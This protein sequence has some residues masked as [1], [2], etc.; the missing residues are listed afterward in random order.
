MHYLSIISIYHIYL[1]YLSIIS[2]YLS[3]VLSIYLSYLSI[4][5]IYLS[6][7]LSIY[8]SFYHSIYLP[9]ILSIYHS[10]YLSSSL[11]VRFPEDDE[12]D[13]VLGGTY[14]ACIASLQ[15]R[16]LIQPNVVLCEQREAMQSQRPTCFLHIAAA[17]AWM[18]SRGRR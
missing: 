18:G 14:I 1:S 4:I 2:I 9:I 10:I 15:L 11:Q 7:Y 5:S 13:D 12:C 8:L 17:R 3:I 16:Y 6:F